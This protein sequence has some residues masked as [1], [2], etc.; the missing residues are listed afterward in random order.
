VEVVCQGAASVKQ[1]FWIGVYV[2]YGLWFVGCGLW[3]VVCGLWV[4][5]LDKFYYP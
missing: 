3:V 1:L 2:F 4:V 5:L